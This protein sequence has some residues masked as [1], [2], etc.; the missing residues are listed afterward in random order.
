MRVVE[1]GVIQ[2]CS[3]I[4]KLEGKETFGSGWHAAQAVGDYAAMVLVI[5]WRD[6]DEAEGF[7]RVRWK[8]NVD[9]IRYI[10]SQVQN[11]ATRTNKITRLFN[12]LNLAWS[13]RKQT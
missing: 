12:W 6:R 13:R 5:H 9:D 8:A 4:S 7:C 10:L 1:S 2:S 3:A 11:R